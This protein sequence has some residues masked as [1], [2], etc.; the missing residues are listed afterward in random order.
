MGVFLHVC[1]EPPPSVSCP[2]KDH[3]VQWRPCKPLAVLIS[4]RPGIHTRNDRIIELAVVRVEPDGGQFVR[5]FRVN[6]QMPIP[7]EATRIHGITDADVAAA[8]PSPR[9]RGVFDLLD[10]CGLGGFNVMRFDIPM[11]AAEFERCGLRLDLTGAGPDASASSTPRTRDLAPPSPSTGHAARGRARSGGGR[12][13]RRSRASAADRAYP[14][15]PA[16]CA[17]LDRYCFGG[18]AAWVDRP[19]VSSG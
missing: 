6:P 10:G 19:A 11:L 8:R 1:A 7:P 16:R 5:A 14:D 2:R 3:D 12:A 15:L 13:S 18:D 9:G 17:L 4:R